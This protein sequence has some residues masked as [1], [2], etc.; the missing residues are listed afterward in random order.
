MIVI[1]LVRSS[2]SADRRACGDRCGV[3]DHLRVRVVH[4]QR[5]D[6]CEPLGVLGKVVRWK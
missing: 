2:S 5:T 3:G 1:C 4:R 6:G